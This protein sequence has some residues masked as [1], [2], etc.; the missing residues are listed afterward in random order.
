MLIG[1][2]SSVPGS[3]K[4]EAAKV[5]WSLGY[6]IEPFAK[7]L[8]QMVVPLLRDLGLSD[9]AIHDRLS[10]GKELPLEELDGLPLRRLL[11]T[12]GT[13]WGRELIHPEL[14]L[15]CWSGRVKPQLA[16]GQPVVVDDVRFPEE[17]ALVEELGGVMWQI[18]RPQALR[19]WERAQVQAHA[20]EGALER[21]PFA[22]RLVND[23]DLTAWQ[24][25][26]QC[27][28]EDL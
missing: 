2:Y 12:I 8:K 16:A 24:Q 18:T 14:W 4:T 27:A 6:S 23:G 22:K 13:D 20:S 17:A 1:L 11:Q 19:Q 25:Q 5:L 21:W 9:A 7:T 3:G 26:V 28:V 10:T 15:R